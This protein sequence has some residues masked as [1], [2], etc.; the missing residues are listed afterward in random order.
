M[1]DAPAPLLFP[2]SYIP[3]RQRAHRRGVSPQS[4]FAIFH[5]D[6]FT[7]R[8]CGAR[9]PNVA[10]EIDHIQPIAAGGG[11]EE[12]NLVTACTDC[13]AG[14]GD[15]VMPRYREPGPLCG[16]APRAVLFGRLT[17]EQVEHLDNQ[18]IGGGLA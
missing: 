12:R 6:H 11:N 4:R 13:N 18:L 3:I 2:G 1:T 10:L 14:K 8:Y 5:R 15:W 17:P 7:C 16:V 9:P